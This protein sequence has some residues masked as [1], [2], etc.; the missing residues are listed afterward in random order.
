MELNNVFKVDYLRQYIQDVNGIKLFSAV[1]YSSKPLP[2][3]LFEFDEVKQLA[4]IARMYNCRLTIVNTSVDGLSGYVSSD[5]TIEIYTGDGYLT[6]NDLIHVFCHE[7]AHCIQRDYIDTVDSTKELNYLLKIFYVRYIFERTAE[8]LAYYIY[9]KYFFPTIIL[10]QSFF[11]AYRSKQSMEDLLEY[12][13]CVTCVGSKCILYRDCKKI[14][15][16]N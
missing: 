11:N 16:K 5:R 7:L 13:G 1:E 9:K 3:T 6:R 4:T 8:T 12:N 2:D 14:A 15:P 10:P